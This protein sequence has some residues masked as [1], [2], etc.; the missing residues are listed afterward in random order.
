MGMIDI[1]DKVYIES[2]G[3]IFLGM[4]DWDF[5]WEIGKLEEN[6]MSDE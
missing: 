4:G 3:L 5:F 6:D 1:H 2:F